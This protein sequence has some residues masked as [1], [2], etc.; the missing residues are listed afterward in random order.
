MG[1]IYLIASFLIASIDRQLFGSTPMY[2]SSFSKRKKSLR[3][4]SVL[5]RNLRHIIVRT[6]LRGL[7][8]YCKN[9]NRNT[10]EYVVALYTYNPPLFV[11]Y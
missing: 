2:R 1:V 5:V 11:V 6:A 3:S 9:Q 7:K 8:S 10:V 4:L